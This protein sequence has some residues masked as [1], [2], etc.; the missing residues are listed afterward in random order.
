MKNLIKY[1]SLSTALC[2]ISLFSA[3]LNAQIPEPYLYYNFEEALGSPTVT[4][5][6]GND[7]EGTVSGNVEFG[8][9]GA[10]SGSTPAGAGQF[11]VGGTGYVTVGGSDAPT[12]FGN[13]DQGIA[14]SYTMACW[15]KPDQG[16]FS[17]DRFI[18]GQGSQGIHHGFRNGNLYHAHWGADF[19]GQS[20]L[21][22]D[23]WAHTTFTYD[24]ETSRGVIY[25]NGEFDSEM[26]GQQGPN[27]GGPLIIGARNG[28]GENYVGLIDD[29]AVWQEVL[30]E[31]SI[32]ALAEGVSP[33]GAGGAGATYSQNFDEYD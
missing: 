27:G 5:Y 3:S 10:P 15:I 29:L 14:A 8:A 16:S 6:S 19:S 28:G 31:E 11:S 18:F 24:S 1:L 12:D 2:L 32:E 22:P 7:R 4:D 23:E 33:I 17:G 20:A 30:P 25:V 9:E 21:S 26:N 13:R